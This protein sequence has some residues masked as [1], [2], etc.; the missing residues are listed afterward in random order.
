MG[1]SHQEDTLY[2]LVLSVLLR[3]IGFFILF[4]SQHIY[5]EDSISKDIFVFE[6]PN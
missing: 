2:P 1:A 3:W 6:S 5:S 4:S